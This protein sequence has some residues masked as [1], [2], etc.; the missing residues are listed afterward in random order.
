MTEGYVLINKS[1]EDPINQEEDS[2]MQSWMKNMN[3][4]FSEE[5]SQKVSKQKRRKAG[6]HHKGQI[7]IIGSLCQVGK[8]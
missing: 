3:R 5:N 7:K 2:T 1:V 6:P 8:G 4:M